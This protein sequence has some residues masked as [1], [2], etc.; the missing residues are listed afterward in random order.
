VLRPGRV[1]RL[2][3]RRHCG[4]NREKSHVMLRGW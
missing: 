4:L 1:G 2:R 3:C